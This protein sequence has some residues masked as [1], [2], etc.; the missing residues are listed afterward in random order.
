MQYRRVSGTG[1]RLVA[2]RRAPYHQNVLRRLHNLVL[3][4]EVDVGLAPRLNRVVD[5]VRQSIVARPSAP[6]MQ[7]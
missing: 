2:G 4:R 3:I 7:P 6:W 1:G 5:R